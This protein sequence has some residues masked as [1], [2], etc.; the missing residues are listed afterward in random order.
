MYDVHKLGEQLLLLDDTVKHWW[1]A[2]SLETGKE[3]YIPSS[4]VA[5]VGSIEAQR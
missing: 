5:S 1:M 2:R 4:Y 3:G